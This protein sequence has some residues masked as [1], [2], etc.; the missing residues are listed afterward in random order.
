[1]KYQNLFVKPSRRAKPEGVTDVQVLVRGSAGVFSATTD[2]EGRY[3]INGVPPGAYGINVL[4]PAGFSKLGVSG[5]FDIKDPRACQVQDFWLH[6]AGRIVG[7]VLEASGQPAA[8]V[9]V[10]IAPSAAP[11]EPLGILLLPTDA[12][13]RFEL[14]DIQPGSYV[15]GLG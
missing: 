12:N 1:M 13:G 2:A 15:V 6:Y 5:G 8:G 11:G 14:Q 4:P 9:R 3:A 7:T 10:E